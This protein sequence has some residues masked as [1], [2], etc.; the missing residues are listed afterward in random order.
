MTD[1]DP[2]SASPYSLLYNFYDRGQGVC[3]YIKKQSCTDLFFFYSDHLL[4][5]YQEE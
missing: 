1:Q 4:V 5:H 2:I 3:H